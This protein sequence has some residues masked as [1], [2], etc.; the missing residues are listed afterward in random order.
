MSDWA[1]V[2]RLI[3]LREAA[4]INTREAASPSMMKYFLTPGEEHVVR[5][6]T[7]AWVDPADF[8]LG[9]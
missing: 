6:A 1:S 3:S 2:T 9:G 7:W 8:L 5:C 4:S